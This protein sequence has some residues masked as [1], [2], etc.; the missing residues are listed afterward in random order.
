[1]AR[2]NAAECESAGTR[3]ELRGSKRK[4]TRAL[5]NTDF[6]GSFR[7][8]ASPETRAIVLQSMSLHAKERATL[9]LAGEAPVE[10]KRLRWFAPRLVGAVAAKGVF[11]AAF[12]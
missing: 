2:S 9:T 3:F 8:D 4:S 7:P 11:A 10:K 5:P 6:E 1:V 12:P